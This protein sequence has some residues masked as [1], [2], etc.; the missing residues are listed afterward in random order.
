MGPPCVLLDIGYIML[1]MGMMEKSK[2]QEMWLVFEWKFDWIWEE[3]ERKLF[4]QCDQKYPRWLLKAF[5]SSL[6]KENSVV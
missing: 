3:Q 4:M 5:Q 2:I 6:D 1:Y